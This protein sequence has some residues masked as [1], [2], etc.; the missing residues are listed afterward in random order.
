MY[1]NPESCITLDLG[2]AEELTASLD[3]FSA[4]LTAVVIAV[5]YDFPDSFEDNAVT[6][7]N[8]Y[9]NDLHSRFV[10]CLNTGEEAAV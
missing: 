1:K 5:Q 8:T 3:Q 2:T 6:A 10:K 4:L 9:F 7:L